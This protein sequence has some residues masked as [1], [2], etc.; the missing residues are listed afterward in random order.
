[1]HMHMHMYM[2]MYMRMHMCKYMP[3]DVCQCH[4]MQCKMLLLD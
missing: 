1:M 4:V 2:Y 3:L